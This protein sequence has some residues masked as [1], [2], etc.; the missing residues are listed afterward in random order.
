MQEDANDQFNLDLLYADAPGVISTPQIHD[1][2]VNTW[3][4]GQ[5]KTLYNVIVVKCDG[6]VTLLSAPFETTFDP[7]GSEESLRN[8]LSMYVR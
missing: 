8:F 5:E 3:R 7:N 1:N 2:I 4:A 6:K